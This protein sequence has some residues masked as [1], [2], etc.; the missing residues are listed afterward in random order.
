M[1]SVPSLFAILISLL[2]IFIPANAVL[3]HAKSSDQGLRPNW[4]ADPHRN[5]V[6]IFKKW[7]ENKPTGERSSA[8]PYDVL[9]PTHPF[10][11]ACYY[12]LFSSGKA[13]NFG[14]KKKYVK[15]RIT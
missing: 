14:D 6:E 9:H 12:R 11:G 2:A 1:K 7:L 3:D 15:K 4:Y 8:L 10:K 13:F 5:R